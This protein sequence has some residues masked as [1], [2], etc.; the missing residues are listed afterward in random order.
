MRTQNGERSRP[1]SGREGVT[2]LALR[3]SSGRT[4]G[5]AAGIVRWEGRGGLSRSHDSPRA[6][7]AGS[8]VAQT[9][10]SGCESLRFAEDTM[11]DGAGRGD[12]ATPFPRQG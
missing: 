6:T 12:D 7:S 2:T 3:L 9:A 11:V 5:R 10:D 4:P 8:T 1:A